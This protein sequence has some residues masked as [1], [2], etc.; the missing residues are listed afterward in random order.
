MK[1]G[2]SSYSLIKLVNN[3]SIKQIDVISLA[4]DIGFDVIE[5]IPFILE[6]GETSEEFCKS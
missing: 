1:I 4:K 3:G 2:V 6:K 5:F